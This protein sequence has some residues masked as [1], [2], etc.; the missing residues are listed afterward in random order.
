MASLTFG[1]NGILHEERLEKS[2]GAI[3]NEQS[4]NTG[5]IVHT[6][7]RTSMIVVDGGGV[8]IVEL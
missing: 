4:R 1:G 5:S 8:T 3:R 6:I 2:E 7:H